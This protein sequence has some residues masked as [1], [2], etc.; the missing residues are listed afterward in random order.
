MATTLTHKLSII[1]INIS[2]SVIHEMIL[3]EHESNAKTYKKLWLVIFETFIDFSTSY[4]STI[5]C[6]CKLT[7]I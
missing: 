3:K 7:P 1:N 6:Q 5:I 4:D 2:H